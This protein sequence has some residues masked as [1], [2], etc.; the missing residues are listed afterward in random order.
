LRTKPRSHF[1]ALLPFDIIVIGSGIGGLT[2][3]ALLARYGKPVLVYESHNIAGSAAYSFRRRG[4]EF[5][6]G[7]S[8]YCG[9]T[10]NE[11]LNP[12]KQVLDILALLP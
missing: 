8:F 5:D 11:S 1:F 12:V 7:P 2:A 4:F 10:G 6:S 3:A 9:L